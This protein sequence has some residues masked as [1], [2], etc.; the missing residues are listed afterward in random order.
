MTDIDDSIKTVAAQ[1]NAQ[2]EEICF[3]TD[4]Q[5]GL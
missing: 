4:V 1:E 3:K 2:A 5:L